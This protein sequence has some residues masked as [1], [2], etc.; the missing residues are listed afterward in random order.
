MG[1]ADA[2]CNNANLGHAKN[3]SFS[4]KLEKERLEAELPVV[5][6]CTALTK[7]NASAGIQLME[8]YRPDI[9]LLGMGVKDNIMDKIAGNLKSTYWKAYTT[10]ANDTV[11]ALNAFL[12]PAVLNGYIYEITDIG[13]S[14]HQS[15]A[16]PPVY[17]T[18]PGTTVADGDL[19]LTCRAYPAE[20]VTMAPWN[21]GSRNAVKLTGNNITAGK[22]RVYNS[23]CTTEYDNGDFYV[24][25]VSG[26]VFQK[27]TGTITSTQALK[28]IYEY[29]EIDQYKIRLNPSDLVVKYSDFDFV[30]KNP[31]T[32]KYQKLTVFKAKSKVSKATYENKFSGLQLDLNIYSAQNRGKYRYGRYFWQ[33]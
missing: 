33:S 27:K 22:I 20:S 11:Y 21:K 8:L 17:P 7:I 9:W 4:F 6:I 25:K 15:G 3:L 26:E 29:T 2:Y 19:T 24:D 13:S 32:G 16:T 28:V 1:A 18:T 23:A 10:R 12:E 14:P 31:N 5:L 30:A